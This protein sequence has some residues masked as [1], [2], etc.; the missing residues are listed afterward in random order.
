MPGFGKYRSGLIRFAVDKNLSASPC[1][2]SRAAANRMRQKCQAHTRVGS[3]V[4]QSIPASTVSGE[5]AVD[6]HGDIGRW[7]SLQRR[8][9]RLHGVHSIGKPFGEGVGYGSRPRLFRRRC[10][11]QGRAANAVDLQVRRHRAGGERADHAGSQMEA[12]QSYL[13]NAQ[14]LCCRAAANPLNILL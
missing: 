1:V 12:T 4:A 3:A 9:I 10:C 5:H 2:R 14:S 7:R 6:L 13:L 8:R 11:G